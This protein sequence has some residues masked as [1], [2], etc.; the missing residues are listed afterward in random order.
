MRTKTQ[1]GSPASNL[2]KVGCHIFLMLML[3]GSTLAIDWP[4]FGRDWTRNASSPEKNPPFRWKVRSVDD[5]GELKPEFNVKW[6]AQ[7]GLGWSVS[8]PVIANGFVWVGTNNEKPRDPAKKDPAPVLMCFRESDGA[9]VWQYLATVPKGVRSDWSTTGIKCSPLIDGNL[10]WFTTPA[11]EVICLDISPLLRGQGTPREVWRLNMVEELGIFAHPLVMGWPGAN[12]VALYKDWIYVNTDNSTDWSHTNVPNPRAPSLVCLQKRTGEVVW[13]DNSPGRNILHI[14]WSSPLALQFEGEGRVFAGLGDGK[15][16]SFDAE[17]GKLLWELDCNP[18]QYRQRKYPMADG[19]S[20]ILATPTFHDGRIYVAIGQEPEH[21]EGVGNLV[22]ADAK[23]GRLVWQ[24]QSLH[25]SI[26]SVVVVD[27]TVYAADFSGIVYGLDIETGRTRWRFD[28]KAHIWGSPLYV[29]GHLFIGDEDGDAMVFDLARIEER[30]Q[31]TGES[32][33]VDD[34]ASS[35]EVWQTSLFVTMYAT[36]VY[37]NGVLYLHAGPNLCAVAQLGGLTGDQSPLEK[38][39]LPDAVFVPTPPDVVERM[40]EM[41]RVQNTDLVVDLGSGDGRIIMLAAR[42]YGSRAIGYEIDPVL[43]ERSRQK[44]EA[45][46]LGHLASVERTDLFKA[47]WQAADVV[48]LY[49]PPRIMDQLLPQLKQ[50]KPGT[51]IV[52]HEFVFSELPPDKTLRMNSTADEAEHH[53]H[54]WTTPLRTGETHKQ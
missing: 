10:L 46:Q 38:P 29:D 40:L 21:G 26:S 23:S 47:S 8:S 19:P 51:R 42:K 7:T 22:C 36:P 34:S 49:L 33:R 37:A 35:R 17:T 24:N 20:E 53:L 13:E 31:K 1:T 41:A 16:R 39:L 27:R 9:F 6:I 18:A 3:A 50:L 15:L 28:A 2:L 11:A 12:S 43:V 25:R 48:A 44:I 14:Q 4:M 32:L 52:S 54:L 30:I 45:D 5:S